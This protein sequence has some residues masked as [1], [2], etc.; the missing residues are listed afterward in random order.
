MDANDNQVVTLL[1]TNGDFVE[2]SMFGADF[3]SSGLSSY[4]YTPPQKLA[5][6]DWPTLQELI[7]D[8]TRLIAFLGKFLVYLPKYLN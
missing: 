8:G 3:V 6:S 7:N 2:A 4:V 5:I 1:L